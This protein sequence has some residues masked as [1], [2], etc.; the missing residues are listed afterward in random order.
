[1]KKSIFGTA[2]LVWWDFD[3]EVWGGKDGEMFVMVVK[4]RT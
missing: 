1:M 4:R 2:V 3:G